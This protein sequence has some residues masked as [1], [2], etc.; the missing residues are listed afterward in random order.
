MVALEYKEIYVFY[1]TPVQKL[2]NKHP[3]VMNVAE[4]LCSTYMQ[5]AL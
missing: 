3:G 4:I 1:N 2:H 5:E